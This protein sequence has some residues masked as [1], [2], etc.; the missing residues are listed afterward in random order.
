MSELENEVQG[1][2]TPEGGTDTPGT[3]LVEPVES[4]S[5][6]NAAIEA[7]MDMIDAL[8]LFD[9]I[10][11][12]ALGTGDDLTCEIAPSRPSEVYLDKGQYIIIDLTINGKHWNLARLTE[13]MDKI[14]EDIPFRT[15]YAS[16]NG[17][18]IVDITTYT[19]PQVIGREVDNKWIM[20]SS[21]AV[22]VKLDRKEVQ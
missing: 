10:T 17:W 19:F 14:H 1:T 9:T 8:D 3:T 18:Q 6:I 4:P 15:S 21:L 13:D 12:G 16:G 11:R 20:A 5:S 22:K 2:E 7:V